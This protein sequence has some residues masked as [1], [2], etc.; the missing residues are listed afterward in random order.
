MRTP[1][2][3]KH[4]IPSSVSSA[5]RFDGYLPNSLPES[6]NALLE[7]PL[8]QTS[9]INIAAANSQKLAMQ[10][11]LII[12]AHHQELNTSELADIA[13]Q[14]HIS[15]DN[16]ITFAYIFGRL[17]FAT[18]DRYTY[19]DYEL[20]LTQILRGLLVQ[21]GLNFPRYY[22]PALAL[23]NYDLNKNSAYILQN[24]ASNGHLHILAYLESKAPDKLQVMIAAG[25]YGAF[26]DAA[27]N[28]H[29]HILAYL[30][31]KARD[32]LQVMIAAG[33]YGAFRDAAKNGH[34]H[35]LAYLASKARDKLQVMIAAGDYGA[36]RDAAKNG[37]LHILA[38]LESKAPDKLPAMIAADN[39]YAFRDAASN[40]HLHI[41]AYLESKAPDKLQAMIAAGDY[42]AFRDAASNGHLHILAYL[43]SKAPDK[44]PAMIAAYDYSAFRDTAINGHLHI[45]E[46]LESKAPDKLQAMIAAYDYYAFR[47]TA[48]NGHL[49]ILEYLASKA[50]DKLQAM[51]AAGDYGAFRD[52][53]KNGHL[54]ILAYLESKAPDKLQ[55]MIAANNYSA[56]R[57]AAK[58]GHLHILAYLE[59]KAPDKLQVMIAAYDYSAFRD[60]ASNG[61]LHILEY[62]ESKAPDKLPAMIDAYDYYS[63]RDA[64]SNGHL[65]ILAY[66]ESKAPDKLQ[67]MIAENDYRAFRFAASHGHLN[68]LEYLCELAPDSLAQMLASDNFSALN[69]LI[70]K[71]PQAAAIIN[72][73]LR[74]PSVFAYAEMHEQEYGEHVNPFVAD[75]LSSL[76]A[77]LRVFE[78]EQPNAVFDIASPE[79]AKLYFYMIRNLIRRDDGNIDDI[80]FLLSIPAVRALAH[81]AVNQGQENELLRL[82]LSL[83]RGET[84]AL[85]LGIPTIRE[86]AEQNDFYRNEQR[87][88]I[89]LQA[90]ARDRE[91]SMTA[92]ASGEQQRLSA[93]I[94]HYQPQI[95]NI[96]LGSVITDLRNTLIARYQANPARVTCE[97]GKTI[98]LPWDYQT[99]MS[100]KLSSNEREQARQAYYQDKNHTAYRYLLKPN[101]WM[102]PSA[103][104]VEVNPSNHQ[105]RWS[106]FEE[107]QPVIAMYFLAAGD[108][109]IAPIDGN[110]LESR[111][112]HFIDELAHIARAH[113]WDKTDRPYEYDDLEGD[114]PSCFS[115]VKRRLF[116]SVLGH[117]LLKI[118]TLDD[119]KQELREF[120]RGHMQAQITTENIEPLKKAW[121]EAI[122][123]LEYGEDLTNLDVSKAQQQ[124]FMN[125]LTAKYPSQLSSE[126]VRYIEKRFADTPHVRSFDGEIKFEQLLN[127]EPKKSAT[128]S[129][130]F[131][132]TMRLT[133]PEQD[134]Q[135]ENNR[136]LSK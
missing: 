85:F 130:N 84:A 123:N 54:H 25:D 64:A 18:I 41:L 40:G 7:K 106:T 37:H 119:I 93:A 27:K 103:S 104:Y 115:G 66:L 127:L 26:R 33:D 86:L 101:P 58:N 102:H 44:L 59:S 57:D 38:Y 79:Q 43:E 118:L 4:L 14:L 39:Y 5:Y 28:G 72:R 111:L 70:S 68:V 126:F 94:L 30:A 113:N 35:I 107:Y 80:R 65:H 90:L 97:N 120:M 48:I 62:L 128:D 99:F 110:T 109:S 61:H 83:E 53:A 117:P 29:L 36:F 132:S 17:D 95:A 69:S 73:G 46:Y 77:E 133:S 13:E 34:L 49:H 81:T 31:S 60:A 50:R 108:A 21:F 23:Y 134:S 75:A 122:I 47:D 67:A 78:R 52:A 136:K 6:L 51:I 121:D 19:G 116:Q 10:S 87:G 82:A 20:G 45:L 1:E 3:I 129:N 76:R 131:F 100:L 2:L 22:E 32:K 124:E 16:Q 24:A 89:D 63:F 8:Q 55:V 74:Y 56:F 91:S 105:E 96:G 135:E 42:R 98:L 11:W 15:N 112:E 92:L 125:H 71:G 12:L 9:V 114:R 88:G